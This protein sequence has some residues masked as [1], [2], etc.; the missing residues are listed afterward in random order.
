MAGGIKETDPEKLAHYCQNFMEAAKKMYDHG[1]NRPGGDM[2]FFELYHH[3]EDC[4]AALRR[5]LPSTDGAVG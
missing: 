3:L 2:W 1:I 5:S 4:A